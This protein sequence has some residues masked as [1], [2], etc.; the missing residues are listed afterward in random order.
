M[1]VQPNMTASS[2]SFCRNSYWI[3]LIVVDASKGD[4]EY[5]KLMVIGAFEIL[6]GASHFD[7]GVSCTHP[8]ELRGQFLD[9]MAEDNWHSR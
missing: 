3:V 2:N 1:T 4:I 9:L 8:E 6:E 7:P 5:Q